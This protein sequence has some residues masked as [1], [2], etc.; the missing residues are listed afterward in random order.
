MKNDVN[1]TRRKTGVVDWNEEIKVTGIMNIIN[2][3]NNCNNDLSVSIAYT[4]IAN[5]DNATID[6]SIILLEFN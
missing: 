4:I 3:I 1:N 6:P 2:P 5:V